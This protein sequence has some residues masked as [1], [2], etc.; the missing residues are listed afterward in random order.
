MHAP[1]QAVPFAHSRLPGHA[2][3][4]AATQDPV[5]LHCSVVRVPFRQLVPHA[6]P[7][8]ACSHDPLAP[9]RPSFPQGWLMLVGH[10][11]EGAALPAS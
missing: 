1:W 3:V 11:P 8:A 10:C 5:P 7:D 9:Q 4:E 6:L 2:I